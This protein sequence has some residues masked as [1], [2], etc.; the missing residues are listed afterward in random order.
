MALSFGGLAGYLSST[1][2]G[3]RFRGLGFVFSGLGSKAVSVGN[4]FYGAERS[5]DIWGSQFCS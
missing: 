2:L 3:F 5:L 1:G 4:F